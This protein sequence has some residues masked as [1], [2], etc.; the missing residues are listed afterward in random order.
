[1]GEGVG[2]ERV[3]RSELEVSPT[4]LEFWREEGEEEGEGGGRGRGGR[5]EGKREEGKREEREKEREG[6]GE[7]KTKQKTC[8]G[9]ICPHVLV[10]ALLRV[11]YVNYCTRGAVER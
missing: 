8:I 7:I 10:K 5:E 2:G 3:F 6:E 11:L 9:L 4:F 1:M